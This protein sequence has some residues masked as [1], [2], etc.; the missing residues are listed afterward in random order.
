MEALLAICWFFF[1]FLMNMKTP[2]ATKKRRNSTATTMPIMVPT[3]SFLTV[4]VEVLVPLPVP[5]V[6]KEIAAAATVGRSMLVV[7]PPV[8]LAVWRTVEM[9]F[10]EVLSQP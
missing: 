9:L 1:F 7:R 8:F 2:I 10:V 3:A 4:R 5:D 6:G